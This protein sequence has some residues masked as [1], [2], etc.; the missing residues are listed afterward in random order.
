MNWPKLIVVD[1]EC[2]K[3]HPAELMSMPGMDKDL[4]TK[5]LDLSTV[6]SKDH[7]VRVLKYIRSTHSIRPPILETRQ[8]VEDMAPVQQMYSAIENKMFSFAIL[9]DEKNTIYSNLMGRCP[10]ES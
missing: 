4:I 3:K 8:E 10:I 6:T 7:M 5:Y 2:I 1:D 9:R